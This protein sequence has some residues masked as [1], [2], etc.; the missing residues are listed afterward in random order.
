[1]K[2]KFSLAIVLALI[3]ITT[4][5]ASSSYPVLG[6]VTDAKGSVDRSASV[7]AVPVQ[8][9][10]S[11]GD[12]GWVH[13]DNKGGFRLSLKPG[14]YII[15]AKDEAEG[16]PDPNLLLCADPSAD[17]PEVLV[18]ASD[19]SGVRVVLGMQGGI[20]EGDVLDASTARG[21][22]KARLTIRDAQDESAFVEFFTDK[23]GHFR[24]TVPRKT[25]HVSAAAAGYNSIEYH[26]GERM[27]L[28]GG[29]HRSM[30]IKLRSE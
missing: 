29:D 16:Y 8:N 2:N 11:A 13:V 10:G 7:T 25:V 12:L 22:A 21:I 23:T 6:I 18:E 9:D 20:L 28:S 5:G 3:N 15:R 1:M 24:F 14:R 26:G 27:T 4:T 19:V 30:V 17:F